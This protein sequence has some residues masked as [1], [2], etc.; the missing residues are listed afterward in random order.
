M[1]EVNN[2]IL[3]EQI[4]ISGTTQNVGV[5]ESLALDAANGGVRTNTDGTTPA[6]KLRVEYKVTT[7]ESFVIESGASYVVHSANHE[8]AQ[9]ETVPKNLVI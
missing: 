3:A 8:Y 9:G 5:D 4:G 2:D 6:N 7:T 1:I